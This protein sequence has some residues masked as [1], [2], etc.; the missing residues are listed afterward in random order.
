MYQEGKN[1]NKEKIFKKYQKEIMKLKNTIIELNNSLEF[2][3]KL[4]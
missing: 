2:N 3:S 1:F 4:D